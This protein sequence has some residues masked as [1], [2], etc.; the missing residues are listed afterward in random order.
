[1]SIE[2]GGVTLSTEER[3][4]QEAEKEYPGPTKEELN[5]I[6]FFGQLG[7]GIANQWGKETAI[8]R[9][10]FEAGALSERNKTIEEVKLLLEQSR[11]NA[12]S[13]R[14]GTTPAGHAFLILKGHEYEAVK[15]IKLLESLKV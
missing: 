1:M 12:I 13:K 2:T 5:G 11:D 15:M 10:S 14:A 7:V 9:V 3:I 6:S 4:K 8:K